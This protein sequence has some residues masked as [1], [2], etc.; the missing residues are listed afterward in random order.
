MYYAAEDI[1]EAQFVDNMWI[2]A[3]A[4]YSPFLQYFSVY[5]IRTGKND[6]FPAHF[7]V[8][9]TQRI[10]VRR[11]CIM[12]L[13]ILMRL[14]LLTICDFG[15]FNVYSISSIFSVDSVRKTRLER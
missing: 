9:C 15:R 14:S 8:E 12:L 13:R 4:M 6:N 2:L 7:S 3:D 11:R 5:S 1:D 10:K